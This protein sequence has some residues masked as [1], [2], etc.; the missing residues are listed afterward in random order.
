MSKCH[1]LSSALMAGAVALG[2]FVSQANAAVTI[3]TQDI[4]DFALDPGS[5]NPLPAT[6]LGSIT[7][8]T[9]SSPGV[10]RSPFENANQTTGPGYGNAYTNIPTGGS[11]TWNYSASNNLSILW[12]SPDSY[13]NLTF[14]SGLDG[15]GSN[16]GSFTGAALAIASVGHDLVTFVA[17]VG[18]FFQSVVLSSSGNAFEFT[19]LVASCEGEQCPAPGTVPLPGALP[20]MISGMVGVGGL[21]GWR[22]RRKSTK[23]QFAAA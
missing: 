15:T 3:N 16:L 2:V 10:T 7:F 12:G 17:G 19:N 20:L 1:L 22:K 14:F 13:N 4:T 18:E 8:P 21:L 11:G 9:L 5:S 6:P 23:A